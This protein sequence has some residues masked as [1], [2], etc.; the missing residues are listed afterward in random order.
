M[1]VGNSKSLIAICHGTPDLPS[2]QRVRRV[3]LEHGMEAFLAHEDLNP[4]ERW[5]ERVQDV[6]AD[7]A[8]LVLML[9]SVATSRRVGEF[10]REIRYVVELGEKRPSGGAFVVPVLLDDCTLPPSLRHFHSISLKTEDDWAALPDW[11][12]RSLGQRRVRKRR[13]A[14]A[15]SGTAR[16]DSSLGKARPPE[17]RESAPPSLPLLHFPEAIENFLAHSTTTTERQAIPADQRNYVTRIGTRFD[18]MSQLAPASSALYGFDC[19]ALGPNGESFQEILRRIPAIHPGLARILMALVCLDSIHS[20][21]SA[22]QARRVAGVNG[23]KF[24]LVLDEEML[25]NPNLG[26]FFSE[27]YGRLGDH[28]TF[29]LKAGLPP[30]Y[31]TL[32]ADLQ[33]KWGLT[34][35]VTG[36]NKWGDQ[37]VPAAIASGVTM[38]KADFATFRRTMSRRD[39]DPEGAISHLSSFWVPNTNF[40]VVGVERDDDILFLERNWPV[41]KCG[42]LYGQGH[43]IACGMPWNVTVKQLSEYGFAAGAF[44]P[45]TMSQS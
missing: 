43:K 10:Q 21:R 29:E 38:S 34:F 45:A 1:A 12:R 44:L 27:R 16:D 4:G 9:Y 33:K 25:A 22:A 19:R 37:Q 18:P 32:L 30:K 7:A 15:S 40:G 11:V 8:A 41:E 31:D 2:A 23:L 13:P 3:L 36:L 42:T 39:Q 24:S 14:A 17:R 26:L 5:Q 20:F 6:L 28:I 35:T